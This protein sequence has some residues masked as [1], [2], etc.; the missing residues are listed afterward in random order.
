[1]PSQVRENSALESLY[2]RGKMVL[3]LEKTW[4]PP[5]AWFTQRPMEDDLHKFPLWLHVLK[6]HKRSLTHTLDP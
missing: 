6:V 3:E 2:E 4:L 5:L 1:M